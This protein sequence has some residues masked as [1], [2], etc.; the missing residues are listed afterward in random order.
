MIPK[1]L[2]WDVI[3]VKEKDIDKIQVGEDLVYQGMT[4]QM[5]GK[6]VTHQLI[7]KE[8]VDGKIVFHTKGIANNSED[9]EVHEEQVQGVVVGKLYVLSLFF[10]SLYNNHFIY[11][12]LV[13]PI[14]IY[15]FFK[16]FH[17]EIGKRQ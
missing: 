12:A 7:R 10:K 9:P 1:Y 15:F 5:A 13:I 16:V 4:G 3:L 14:T 8:E 2:I 6:T 11:Y 17:K